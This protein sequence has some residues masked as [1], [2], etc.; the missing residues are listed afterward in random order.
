VVVKGFSEATAAGLSVTLGTL[1]VIGSAGASNDGVGLIA[2][3]CEVCVCAVVV[4]V[5]DCEIT[6]VSSGGVVIMP[7]LAEV[8]ACGLLGTD[9]QAVNPIKHMP[10]VATHTERDDSKSNNIAFLFSKLYRSY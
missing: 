7:V 5:D 10:I 2:I 1:W 3:V 9:S 4:C 6:V 8:A